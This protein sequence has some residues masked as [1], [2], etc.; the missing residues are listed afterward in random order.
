M[1]AS[2][3]LQT[4]CWSQSVLLIC[5]S[6]TVSDFPIDISDWIQVIEFGNELLYFS[7]LLDVLTF[8]DWLS[9]DGELE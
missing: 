7:S 6:L 1:L 2:N 5:E 4:F 9:L 8:F 3:N